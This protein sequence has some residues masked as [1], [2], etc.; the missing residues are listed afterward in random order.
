MPDPLDILELAED[1]GEGGRILRVIVHRYSGSDAERPAIPAHFQCG[2][3]YGSMTQGL[4]D[5]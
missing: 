5:D 3:G 4:N 1:G 2:G